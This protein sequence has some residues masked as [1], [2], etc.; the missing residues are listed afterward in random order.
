MWLNVEDNL[1]RVLMIND[2]DK[3][4][5]IDYLQKGNLLWFNKD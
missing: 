2:K 4:K 5:I 1:F 3:W